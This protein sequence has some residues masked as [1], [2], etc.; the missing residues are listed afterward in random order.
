MTNTTAS[1]GSSELFVTLYDKTF[2]ERAVEVTRY[3]MFGQQKRIPENNGKV[4]SFTR[5][6][7]LPTKDFLATE[8]ATAAYAAGGETLETVSVTAEIRPM[9]S[10]IDQ[11][12]LAYRSS[13]D[14]DGEELARVLGDQCGR[15]IDLAIAKELRAG[16]SVRQ[17]GNKDLSAIT[18]TDM[19][20]STEIRRIA[21]QLALNGARMIHGNFTKGKYGSIIPVSVA[22]DL[23]N[24]TDWKTHNTH[25]DTSGIEY[26]K[27]GTIHGIDFY[28]TNAENS[29]RETT[30]GV[31]NTTGIVRNSFF[32]G[33]DAYGVIQFDGDMGAVPQQNMGKEG[34]SKGQTGTISRTKF[35][36]ETD[37]QMSVSDPLALHRIIA[38]KIYFATKV[39]NSDWVINLKS[40]TG[41]DS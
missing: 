31:L 14:K 7:N 36:M 33:A 39:L 35:M 24:D 20:S 11:T 10:F 41:F 37:G 18:A 15:S 16:A 40:G 13:L 22:Y 26:G 9:G 17:V 25:V 27:I 12:E 32:F 6:Q 21:S 30:G 34:P 19:I 28:R 29:L 8:D 2:L 3:Q 1:S 38:W 4:V 23:Q 5:Y